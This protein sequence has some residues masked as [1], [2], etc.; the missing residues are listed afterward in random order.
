[1]QRAVCSRNGP[2]TRFLRYSS[3]PE[4]GGQ[5]WR[6]WRWN[7]NSRSR[8]PRRLNSVFARSLTPL[9]GPER[10]DDSFLQI[11]R[12]ERTLSI[13]GDQSVRAGKMDRSRRAPTRE[14][15]ASRTAEVAHPVPIFPKTTATSTPEFAVQRFHLLCRGHSRL[16]PP[17]WRSSN[18]PAL[19][20]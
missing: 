17:R 5:S 14:P 9:T 18:C 1:M 19:E 11:A 15:R 10:A 4:S 16:R 2:R 20:I 7:S 6:P 8:Q 3:C 13:G 12:A